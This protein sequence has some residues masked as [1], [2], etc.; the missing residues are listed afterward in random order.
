MLEN[1][2]HVVFS[3]FVSEIFPHCCPVCRL[4]F[5]PCKSMVISYVGIFYFQV[6]FVPI[7]GLSK[8]IIFYN[9]SHVGVSSEGPFF[10]LQ[11]GILQ[12]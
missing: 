7:G 4:K 11:I 12:H 10:L 6:F 2:N 3:K 5:E 8:A 1:L 9:Q